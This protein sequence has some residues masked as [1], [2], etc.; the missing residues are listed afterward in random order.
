MPLKL[1]IDV[2]EAK[3]DEFEINLR[4][5]FK[6]LEGKLTLDAFNTIIEEESSTIQKAERPV[7]KTTPPEDT[8]IE[9]IDKKRKELHNKGNK[10]KEQKIEYSELDKTAKKDEERK[11]QKEKKR[12]YNNNFGKRKRTKRNRQKGMQKKDNKHA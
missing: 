8:R 11:K 12:I 7:R 9:E 4:N 2:L 3:R 1:R 10:T 5:R 6:A